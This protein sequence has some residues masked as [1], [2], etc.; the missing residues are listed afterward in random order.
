VSGSTS[1]ISA[2][3]S[4]PGCT[5]DHPAILAGVELRG[6]FV[7]LRPA[8]PE[9]A[10]ALAAILAEPEVAAWWGRWDLERVN[11]HL[12][13]PDPEEEPFAIERDGVVVGYIQVYEEDEP[14]F[15]HAALDLFI[16][17]NLQG[18]GFGPDAITTLAAHLIDDRGHHRLSIDPAAANARAIA[19]YTKVG[20]RPVGVMRRYQRLGDGTW[21]DALLMDLL[22][23][24][25][26]R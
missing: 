24:E 2:N 6:R 10:P 16:T 21:V 8:V 26:V 1:I 14:D 25:L 17:T 22:A 4:G 18:R 12:L 9:D 7:T 3:R 13:G 11:A 15:R 20:F 5:G 19:A 23:D